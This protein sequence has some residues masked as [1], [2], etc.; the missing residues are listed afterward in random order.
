M[1]RIERATP[2]NTEFVAQHLRPGDKM[3]LAHN[4]RVDFAAAVRESVRVS[5]FAFCALLDGEPVCVFG[6]KPDGVI[7]KRACVWLLG[8]PT[9]NTIKKGFAKTC[10]MVLTGLWDI[11]PELYN[12]VDA[13]YPQAIRLLQFLGAEFGQTVKSETGHPVILFELRRKK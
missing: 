7:S 12:A 13:N 11:Y 5:P 9:L 4:G 3:E 10:R 2:E 6:L 1:I 8:T